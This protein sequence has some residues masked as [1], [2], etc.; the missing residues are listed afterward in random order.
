MH[1]SSMACMVNNT[2]H[3]SAC[4]LISYT[5]LVCKALYHSYQQSSSIQCLHTH[6]YPTC[7]SHKHTITTRATNLS[8]LASQA[9]EADI[10]HATNIIERGPADPPTPPHPSFLFFLIF[11]KLLAALLRRLISYSL[12]P[13]IWKAF[14]ALLRWLF[15]RIFSKPYVMS[16][17]ESIKEAHTCMQRQRRLGIVSTPEVQ[18]DPKFYIQIT[19]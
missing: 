5:G 3:A 17:A 10:P 14:L 13:Y 8:C 11:L 18:Y 4:F 1:I 7:H 19:I 2:S 16:F 6:E 12:F 9:L 15:S